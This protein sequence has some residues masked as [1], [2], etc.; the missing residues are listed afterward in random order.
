MA[1]ELESFWLYVHPPLAIVGYLL[2]YL[3]TLMLFVDFRGIRSRFRTEFF[4]AAAWLFTLLG[5]IT[6]M[7]WA[8]TAWGTYWSWDPKETMTLVL[9]LAVSASLT[10][11]YEKHPGLAK[12]LAVLSCL[13]TILTL[14]AS[15]IIQGLHSF[16]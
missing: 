9:F 12:A 14:S 10:A 6:G 7:L 3:F 15:W 16:A 8:Q 4:G 11:Y 13:L 2:I 1:H 5:L